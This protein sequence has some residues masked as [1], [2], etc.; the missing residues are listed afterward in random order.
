MTRSARTGTSATVVS[1]SDG[2]GKSAFASDAGVS[3]ASS[4]TRPRAPQPEARPGARH[5]RDPH[6]GA[7]QPGLAAQPAQVVRPERRARDDEER[8]G[9]EP[10]HRHVHLDAA[11]LVQRLRVDD[12]AGRPPDVPGEHPRAEPRRVRPGDLDLGEGRLVEQRPPP[13]A[14]PGAPARRTATSAAPPI[15][16]AAAPRPRAS[17]SGSPAP[18][19]PSPRSSPRARRAR[20]RRATSAAGVPPTARRPGSRMS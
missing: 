4:V 11:A 16:A 6:V 9:G 7:G 15:P 18:N 20:R 10:R 3:G 19:P 1:R 17:R 13:R 2:Y 12:R 14:P 8:V 5:V